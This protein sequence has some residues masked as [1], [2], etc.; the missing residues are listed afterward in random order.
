MN[1]L[2]PDPLLPQEGDATSMNLGGGQGNGPVAE[3]SQPVSSAA[4]SQ[5]QPEFVPV[6]AMEAML[7][8]RH[9]QIFKW[10]H[11]LEA[12]ASRPLREFA[13]DLRSLAAA[14]LEDVQFHKP[15]DQLERHTVKLGAMAMA[16][17]DRLQTE[18][19]KS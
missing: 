2:F 6:G 13:V 14:I 11:T 4:G 3:F 19:G 18:R 16:F 12:D 15:V 10:G 8:K 1:K 9:E 7:A 17:F 5:C